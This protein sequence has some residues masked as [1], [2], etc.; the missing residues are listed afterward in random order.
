AARAQ[1]RSALAV[2][3]VVRSLT[4]RECSME[5]ATMPLRTVNG[6]RLNVEDV[7][8]GPETIVFAHGLLWSGGMY[9]AQVKSLRDRY[10]CVTFDFRGQGQ[11]EVTPGGYDMDTLTQDAKALIEDLGVAPVHFVGL[12]MGG[13]VGFRLA[14]RHAS[15]LRSLVILESAAD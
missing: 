5:R 13:F 14:A 1:A 8:T 10:R 12:S 7:G 15:L 6:V 9:A 11:S 4:G 3:V 2:M